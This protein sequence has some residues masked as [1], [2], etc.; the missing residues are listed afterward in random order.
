LSNLFLLDPLVKQLSKGR[1]ISASA[2]RQPRGADLFAAPLFSAEARTPAGKSGRNIYNRTDE[3]IIQKR[4]KCHPVVT[5][6]TKLAET[7]GLRALREPSCQ[8]SIIFDRGYAIFFS[9]LAD[10]ILAE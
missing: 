6:A 7:P 1:A 10:I 9:H 2:Q 8:E 4:H 3:A 5:H